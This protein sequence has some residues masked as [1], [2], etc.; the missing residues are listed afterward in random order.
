MATD[1]PTK[2]LGR[3]AY[4]SIGHLPASRMGPGDHSVHAGQAAICC[5]RARKGDTIIVQEKLDGSC[6]S[7][8]KLNGT[9]HALGRA[10]WPAESSPYVQHRHFANW[11]LANYERFNEVLND[12]ERIVGEWLMQAHGTR[13][14]L[15]NREPFV[16][17]DIMVETERLPF[18]QFEWRIH[19]ND[20]GHMRAKPL[21]IPMTLHFGIFAVPLQEALTSLGV[22]GYYGAL[23]QVE[24][25]VYRVER[26]D[27]VDFLA[28]Y[29]RPDK[30]D[31]CYLPEI[32]GNASVWNWVAPDA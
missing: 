17:F 27:R 21:A 12:G 26:C 9:L 10:G 32:S 6:V 19:R 13:Y 14:D 1:A 24:G 8:A 30:I 22:Y 5:Q 16:A 29:V 2:P 23:D 11:V 7:V 15:G 25:V 20:G 3:K 18:R 31:G 28:K 4:G